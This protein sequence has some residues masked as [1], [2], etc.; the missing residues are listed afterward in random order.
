MKSF[1]EEPTEQKMK[2]YYSTLTEKAARHYASVEALKL[3]YGG[4]SYISPSL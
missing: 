1:Y 4:I 3:G 2:A